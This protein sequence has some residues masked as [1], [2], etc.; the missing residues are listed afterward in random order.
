LY[1]PA[2]THLPELMVFIMNKG[3]YYDLL[4]YFVGIT[5][6]CLCTHCSLSIDWL[7]SIL[8]LCSK[9]DP[10]CWMAIVFIASNVFLTAFSAS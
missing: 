3:L 2:S 9:I 7:F 6:V 1:Q 8:L 10:A 4:F 5:F